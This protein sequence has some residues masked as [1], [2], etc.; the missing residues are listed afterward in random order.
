MTFLELA[1]EEGFDVSVVCGEML[2]EDLRVP[3]III[4]RLKKREEEGGRGEEQQN[5]VREVEEQQQEGKKEG[6]KHQRQE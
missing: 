5:Q 2:P 1:V 3:D 4:A 6:E